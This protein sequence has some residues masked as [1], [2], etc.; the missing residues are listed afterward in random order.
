[1]KLLYKILFLLFCLIAALACYS[2][3]SVRGFGLFIIL[4]ALFEMG[5]WLGLFKIKTK[6]AKNHTEENGT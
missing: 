6:K 1:M 3:G 4:G 5:F 2:A